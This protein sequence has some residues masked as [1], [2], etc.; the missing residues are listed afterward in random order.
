VGSSNIHVNVAAFGGTGGAGGPG[1]Q[2]LGGSGPDGSP[3][4][5]GSRLAGGIHDGGT[6][7]QGTNVEVFN[8]IVRANSP[9]EHQG[10]VFYEYSNIKGGAPGTGNIDAGVQFVSWQTFDYRLDFDSPCID[11]GNKV[12]RAADAADVD[13]DGDVAEKL[14]LDVDL[15]VRSADDL[16][17]IDTGPSAGSNIDMG[18]HERSAWDNLENGMSGVS[19]QPLFLGVGT[20]AG[21]DAFVLRCSNTVPSSLAF[22]VFSLVRIDAPAKGGV[23]VP[24]PSPPALIIA[25]PSDTSGN[26]EIAGTWPALFPPG[27]NLYMQFWIADADGPVG[28]AASNGVE[29]TTF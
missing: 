4:E 5:A 29:G 12:L 17:V 3:G 25:F 10:S 14:P 22:M 16:D 19:G 28:Y 1:G 26:V 23:M 7:L 20:L 8:S 24:S 15:E 2:G 9:D 6:I 18:A 13:R 27:T 21:G 11:A